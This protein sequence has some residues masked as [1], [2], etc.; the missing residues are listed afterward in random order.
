MR[1]DNENSHGK[2]LKPAK[3]NKLESHG[4]HWLKIL[5]LAKY[6]EEFGTNLFDLATHMNPPTKILM[7]SLISSCQNS[8]ITNLTKF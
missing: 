6:A 4:N 2:F 8:N 3:N 7:I 1:T 5:G